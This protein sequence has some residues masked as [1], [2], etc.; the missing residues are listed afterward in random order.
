[1]RAGITADHAVFATKEQLTRVL[2]EFGH[3]VR[4]LGLSNWSDFRK[5]VTAGRRFAAI[6]WGLQ[7]TDNRGTVHKTSCL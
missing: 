2:R 4:D 5:G 1:M 6:S 7:Q 3:E